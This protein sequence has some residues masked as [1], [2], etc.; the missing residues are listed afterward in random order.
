MAT[1]DKAAQAAPAAGSVLVVRSRDLIKGPPGALGYSNLI[2]P[3][4]AFNKSQF[5]ASVHYS[6][7]LF[8]NLADQIN[9]AYWGLIPELLDQA[10]ERK[11]AGDKKKTEADHR[12]KV[13]VLSKGDLIE[14]LREKLKDANDNSPSEDPFFTFACNSSYHDKKADADVAITVKGWDPHGAP[15]D[16]KA[17]KVGKGSIVKPMFTVGVWAGS[18]PFSKWVALPTIRFT[19]LQILKLEQWKGS[20]GQTAVGEVTESDLAALGADFAVSDLSMFVQKDAPKDKHKEPSAAD[21]V[22]MDDEIPF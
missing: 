13:T 16:L 10:V 7:K 2:V 14:S 8:N 20:G 9:E 12:K 6:A 3:D 11:V 4:E 18:S 5:K 1:R 22:D 21:N 19:G 17:A 15:L